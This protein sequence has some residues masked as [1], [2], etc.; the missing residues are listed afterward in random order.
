MGSSAIGCEA[1]EI[2]GGRFQLCQKIGIGGFAE[3]WLA[4]DLTSGEHVALKAQTDSMAGD[5]IHV[6]ALRP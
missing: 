4:E 2:L 5:G 1:G 6:S 3:V